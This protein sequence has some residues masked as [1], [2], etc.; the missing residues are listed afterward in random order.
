ML[1]IDDTD[2]IFD[3]LD[4]GNEQTTGEMSFHGF[5]RWWF[6]EKDKKP[7]KFWSVRSFSYKEGEG[8]FKKKVD[9]LCIAEVQELIAS[10]AISEETEILTDQFDSWKILKDARKIVE[11]NLA[12]TAK[13]SSSMIFLEEDGSES[14][15]TSPAEMRDYIRDSVINEETKVK[16]GAG[17]A[18][19][20]ASNGL[21]G[22][23]SEWM[24]LSEVKHVFGLA[25]YMP[26]ATDKG[27]IVF[28]E[29][30]FQG[31]DISELAKSMEV[32]RSALFTIV[33]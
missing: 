1:S 31:P 28:D 10:G 18:G 7:P 2:A 12:L 19:A 6:N 25:E 13:Y 8:E 21:G 5:M 32:R 20:E 23:I 27:G 29:A 11:L 22:I 14:P 30:D 26:L 3:R 4:S 24:P 16:T 33:H 9:D 15:E 17:A